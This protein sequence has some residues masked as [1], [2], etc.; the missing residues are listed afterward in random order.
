MSEK[1]TDAEFIAECEGMQVIRFKDDNKD[2]L[3]E[4]IERLKRAQ[5]R[6]YEQRIGFDEKR[7]VASMARDER[8]G[9]YEDK[10][11]ELRGLLRW[12]HSE[13]DFAHCDEATLAR[14]AEIVKEE[15]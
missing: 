11:A 4:A 5:V 6:H 7:L 8:E 2:I 1:K 9:Y 14:I 15:K 13:G 12:C 3:A 10:I